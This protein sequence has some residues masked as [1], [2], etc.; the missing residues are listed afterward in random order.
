MREL[1]A[2]GFKAGRAQEIYVLSEGQK[3][4][5]WEVRIRRHHVANSDFLS[6][7]LLAPE[8]KQT[9]SINSSAVGAL[10]ATR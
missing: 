3:W 4:G 8:E 10:A 6:L 2:R 5:K 9:C 1:R 7:D